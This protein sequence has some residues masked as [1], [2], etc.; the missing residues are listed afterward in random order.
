[1]KNCLTSVFRFYALFFSVWNTSQL[2]I[3]NIKK[4]SLRIP[5]LYG[6]NPTL[7]RLLNHSLGLPL[8]LYCCLDKNVGWPDPAL[9]RVSVNTC[10]AHV[11]TCDTMSSNPL[12]PASCMTLSPEVVFSVS[13]GCNENTVC[14]STQMQRHLCVLCSQVR[15]T[16]E[17]ASQVLK[18]IQPSG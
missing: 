10:S 7:W 13:L 17:E 18:A 9:L 8:G 16:R 1:M 6:P 15:A 11:I 14:T 2:N 3:L 4:K 5:I 12:S